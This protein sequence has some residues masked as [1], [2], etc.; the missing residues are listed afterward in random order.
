MAHI[1]FKKLEKRK[2]TQTFFGALNQF[3]GEWSFSPSRSTWT[4]PQYPV[5]GYKL[6]YGVST[7]WAPS[8]S[9]DWKQPISPI[10]PI[11]VPVPI[12]GIS[13]SPWNPIGFPKWQNPISPFDPPTVLYGISPSPVGSI[14]IPD[15]P[16]DLMLSG[17]QS[18]PECNQ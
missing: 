18:F 17:N 15:F 3:T 10:F 11:D 9:I 2:N 13:P 1:F 4:T 12:Y 7:P 16:G 6:L 8:E 5:S 14:D